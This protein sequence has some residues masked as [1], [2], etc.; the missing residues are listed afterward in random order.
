MLAYTLKRLGGIAITLL[1]LSIFTFTLSRVVPGGPWMQGAEIPMSEQ[2]IQAF[3]EKY[4]LD[5]PE[6]K[7]YLAWL[8]N[9][10]TLDFGQTFTEPER[11][12]QELIISALPY[13]AL[14]G[15]LAATL[16]ITLGVTLG[17]V[18]AAN[19]DSWLDNIVTSY[20]VII[21]TIPSFVMGFVLVYFLA[22][23]LRWF[24]AGSWGDPSNWKD[25]AWHLVLPVTAYGLPA[26]G[27]VARW[28]RQCIAEAMAADYVRTA[29]AKG[30]HASAVMVRHVLRNALI[31]MI[32]NFLPLYPGMMTGSLF[33]ESVFGLPGLGKY[34][35]MS[36]TNRD[37][38]LV[39]GIT[40]FWALLIAATYLLTDILYG[41]IDPRVRITE[42]AK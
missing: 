16:A 38:P 34:F 37:Y 28:T 5:Q 2:Q 42:R 13:S 22:V 15:G 31:P 27:G 12:V 20:A 4:G 10:L 8:R 23:K 11:T 21:S 32:T 17:I 35:V 9:A 26:T 25:V 36:S 3:K 30:L 14:V 29:Y 40:M 41:I 24:P 6:W 18:A 39:L 19:Q 7:Q 33:I 1:L